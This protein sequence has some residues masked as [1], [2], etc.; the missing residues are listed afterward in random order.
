ML[1]VVQSLTVTP[2][3]LQGV[4]VLVLIVHNHKIHRILGN[5]NEI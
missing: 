5:E 1:Q 3:Q 2:E 4:I